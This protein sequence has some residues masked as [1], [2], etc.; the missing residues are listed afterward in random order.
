MYRCKDVRRHPSPR[1]FEHA[2]KQL[3]LLFFDLPVYS[4]A[5][6]GVPAKEILQ[7]HVAA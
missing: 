3:L 7:T 5:L 2:R 6:S 1:E 4:L